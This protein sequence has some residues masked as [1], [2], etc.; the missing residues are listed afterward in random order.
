MWTYHDGQLLAE[1]GRDEAQHDTPHGDAQPEPRGGHARR[2]R[3]AAAD[4]EHEFHDPAAESDLDAHVAQQEEGAEPGDAC[5]GH[6]EEGL[7]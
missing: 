2:E 1:H 7:F 4:L 6:I 3:L 5:G